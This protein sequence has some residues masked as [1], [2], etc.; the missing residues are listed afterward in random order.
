MMIGGSAD[1][2][3]STKVYLSNMFDITPNKFDGKN[4]WFGIREHSMGAIL[5]GLALLSFA[6][7]GG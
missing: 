5:N 3:S 6:K 2:N 1:L 4:I 7:S